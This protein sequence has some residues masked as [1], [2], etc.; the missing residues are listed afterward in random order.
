MSTDK[1]KVLEMLAAGK[2]TPEDAERLLSRLGEEPGPGNGDGSGFTAGA[3]AAA[4]GPLRYLRS[5]ST[6]RATR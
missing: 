3:P 6:A 4:K 5:W 2:I 1:R